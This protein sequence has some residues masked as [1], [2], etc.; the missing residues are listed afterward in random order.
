[1]LPLGL[2]AGVAPTCIVELVPTPVRFSASTLGYN[3][4]AAIFGGT[5]PLLAMWL[6]QTT[7]SLLSPGLYLVVVGLLT[8][9][10]VYNLVETSQIDLNHSLM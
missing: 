1:M 4:G 5:T 9:L 7:G 6:I 2:Y 10:V 8:L 3:V